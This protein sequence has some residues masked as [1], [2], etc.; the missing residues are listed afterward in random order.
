MGV[1]VGVGVGVGSMCAG[2]GR[3]GVGKSVWWWQPVP[4]LRLP[5]GLPARLPAL[6]SPNH[7]TQQPTARSAKARPPLPAGGP[8]TV[9]RW[10][11]RR[12]RGQSLPG[13]LPP[14][15]RSARRRCESPPARSLQAQRGRRRGGEGRVGG[16]QGQGRQRGWWC[17]GGP[18]PQQPQPSQATH[19]PIHPVSATTGGS[20]P[21]IDPTLLPASTRGSM[22]CSSSALTTPRW[23]APRDPPPL[24]AAGQG[25][26]GR[27]VKRGDGLRH[28]W[29]QTQQL[30]APNHWPNRRP[31]RSECP[32]LPWASETTP[33]A[34]RAH[35][36]T[37][38]VRPKAC[39]VSF[40]KAALSSSGR[41]AGRGSAKCGA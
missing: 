4:R 8:G 17:H 11:M 39:R 28:A 27:Q 33:P 10:R 14:A 31:W 6:P 19:P 5:P 2:G 18:A 25:G 13:C 41:S 34:R 16:A 1:G 21:P 30:H 26:P 23:N 29:Q 24:Q 40:R 15:C 12:R 36:S 37:R 3:E 9:G 35:L 7:H 38:A 32:A 20:P 22:W